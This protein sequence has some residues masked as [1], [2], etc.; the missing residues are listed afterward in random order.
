MRM[1]RWFCISHVM[2]S[3]AAFSA[4]DI[5]NVRNFVKVRCASN[6]ADADHAF[7][8]GL[9]VGVSNMLALNGEVA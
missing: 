1:M 4:T 5:V 8:L 9:L 2:G 6:T 3:S 7:C